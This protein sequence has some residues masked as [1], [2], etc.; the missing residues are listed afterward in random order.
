MKHYQFTQAIHAD[1]PAGVKQFR[2]GDVIEEGAIL[3]GCLASCIH[4]GAVAEL[5]ALPKAATPPPA[6]ETTT[7]V[8]PAKEEP[9]PAPAKIHQ[10]KPAA[11]K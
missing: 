5:E 7:P 6:P 10:P 11:K 9:A 8:T 4:T 1:T 2:A 3:P